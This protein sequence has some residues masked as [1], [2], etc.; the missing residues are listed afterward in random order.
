MHG[1]GRF[2]NI[3]TLREG[4]NGGGA[5]T[6]TAAYGAHNRV[7]SAFSQ[8]YTYD[9]AGRITSYEGT[10][11]GYGSVHKHAVNTVAGTDRYDYDANGNVVKRDK[12]LSTQ[13]TLT[14]TVESRLSALTANG[15][16]ESYLYDADAA[17]PGRG[18]RRCQA[19]PPPTTPSCITKSRSMARPP[20]SPSITS[21]RVL[22]WP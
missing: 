21:S 19:A 2:A 14:Y 18:S 7:T 5:A 4:F 9:A 16:S 13:Q 10:S 3:T 8:S 12:G 15:L 1:C 20:L 6:W 22:G 11:L 17:P